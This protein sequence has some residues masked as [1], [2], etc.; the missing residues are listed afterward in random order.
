MA[1]PNLG[2]DLITGYQVTRYK[3]NHQFQCVVTD[4][5]IS[6]VRLQANKGTKVL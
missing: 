4:V 3:T 2:C 5:R 1:P 6:S